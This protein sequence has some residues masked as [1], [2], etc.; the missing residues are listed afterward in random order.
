MHLVSIIIP[1]HFLDDLNVLM[2]IKAPKQHLLSRVSIPVSTPAPPPPRVECLACTD[3][4]PL[5]DS[6]QTPCSHRYCRDCASK[7]VQ[8]ATRDE[9][10]FPPRCCRTPIPISLV[11]HF[12][13]AEVCRVFEEK[14]VEHNDPARTYC[15]NQTCSVYLRP[16]VA[17]RQQNGRFCGRCLIWTCSLCKKG[18]RPNVD[19]PDEDEEVL[20][21]GQQEGWRSCPR[22]RNLIELTVGC[23]HMT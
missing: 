5:P 18:H 1:F 4:T 7:L 11:R 23:N 13:T 15:S 22:C 8:D 12:L 6:I 3:R 14:L 17:G 20:V 16:A 19:C 21:L 2:T 10:L 9:T